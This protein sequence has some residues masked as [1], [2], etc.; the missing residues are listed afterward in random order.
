M[1]DSLVQRAFIM[2]DR[3][4]SVLLK[5]NRQRQSK[6]KDNQP[7]QIRNKVSSTI[8]NCTTCGL[9][10]NSHTPKMNSYG[11]GLLRIAIVGQCPS[12]KDDRKGVSFI[13]SSGVFL[14]ECLGEFG[15]DLDR[16][17]LRTNAFQCVLPSEKKLKTPAKC[18]IYADC[19]RSRLEQQLDNFK[20]KLIIAM[21]SDAMRAVLRPSFDEPTVFR[22]RGLVFPN[23]RFKCWTG[24]TFHPSFIIE[25]ESNEKNIAKFKKIFQDDLALSLEY[26]D[27]PLPQIC[28]ENHI[29]LATLEEVKK[30][31][32]E[33]KYSDQPP[34][35]FDYE[36]NTLKLYNNG[37][38]IHCV[39]FSDDDQ[40]GYFLP[41]DYRNFWT[42]DQLIDVMCEFSD[43]LASPR[44]KVV[45]NLSMEE[46]WSAEQIQTSIKNVIA[47]TMVTHHVIYNREKTSGLDFQSFLISGHDYKGVIDFDNKNWSE[48]EPQDKVQRYSVWDSQNTI[49]NFNNQQEFL[50]KNPGSKQASQFF[51]NCYPA[52]VRMERSGINIDKI[53]LDELK[54]GKKDNVTGA[55][56]LDAK[57]EPIEKGAFQQQKELEPKID[58]SEFVQLFKKKTGRDSW[59]PGSDKDFKDLFY[60]T[61]GLE[62]PPWKTTGGG[63]PA[64]KEAVAYIVEHVDDQKLSEFCK[65]MMDWRKLDTLITTFLDGFDELIQDDGLIHPGFML[66]TVASYRSSSSKPNFQNLPK[67]DEAYSEFRKIVIPHSGHHSLSEIDAA[68]SEVRVIAML[69]ED[70]IL[71]K[72]VKENFD[73]H[74]YWG[75]RLFNC[76]ID[77]VTKLQRFLAKNK[78]VF[79][80]F[81]GSW[82]GAVSRDCK[83]PMEHCK[84]IEEEFW[85]MYKGVKKWQDAMI[86]FYNIHGYTE[87]PLGFRR[88]NPLSKN[89]VLNTIVQGTSFHMLLESL[90][91]ADL[92]ILNKKMRSKLVIEVHDSIVSSNHSNEIDDIHKI[93]YK[94][95]TMKQWAW[96][97]DIPRGAD[98]MTG[99]NWGEMKTIKNP[100]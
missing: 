55:Y 59:G 38:R 61:L 94:A 87:F 10:E 51:F 43:W 84:A 12:Q 74:A 42:Q 47:D 69:S 100:E 81:Y 62:P 99:S 46:K 64:D 76:H 32:S 56:I 14:S 86:G 92:E 36:T 26:L 85:Q 40:K 78:M 4:L 31:F 28:P 24:C 65:M 18:K 95:M 67:R 44:K 58:Q 15:L 60:D 63:L 96:Q 49:R 20:P 80:L 34:M 68:G 37:A 41:L 21:G 17:F 7:K 73:P 29:L 53:L 27:I 11:E 54:H 71:S 25:E 75:S 72:Q 89:Q 82:Y 9:D 3:V 6:N 19:C 90:R 30:F 13:D 48:V 88:H 1:I 77:K 23:H 79:P 52:L 66:H 33:N 8:R 57:G 50:N 91:V 97:R 5:H 22:Y 45:Q 70:I 83:L 98:L 39:S 93:L 35:A 16:D 2:D